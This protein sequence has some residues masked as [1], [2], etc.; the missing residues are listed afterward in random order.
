MSDGAISLNRVGSAHFSS[1]AGEPHLESWQDFG[2]AYAA[3][4][5]PRSVVIELERRAGLRPPIAVPVST[6][7]SLTYRVIAAI[8]ATTVF[9]RVAYECRN[10]MDDNSGMGGTIRRDE[11]FA[12]FPEPR[13]RAAVNKPGDWC[14]EPACRFWFIKR[15]GEPI[16]AL[17]PGS[18]FVWNRA[19]LRHDLPDL[20]PASG[21]RV[22][23]L[24]SWVAG[25]LFA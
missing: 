25:D 24:A 23:L 7:Q 13:S 16:I 1:F 22:G 21:K 12:P 19:G 5:D 4:K 18:G 17:E 11:L 9:G 10:G 8:L 14:D 6:P 3:A 2:A 20:W 15:E